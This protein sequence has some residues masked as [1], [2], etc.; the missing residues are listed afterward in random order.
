MAATTHPALSLALIFGAG[1]RGVAG[2]YLALRTADLTII[3]PIIVT[4]MFAIQVV[5]VVACDK[6][7]DGRYGCDS[8]RSPNGTSKMV[9]SSLSMLSSSSSSSSGSRGSRSL[10]SRSMSAAL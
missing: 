3:R 10:A 8:S 5:T 1:F 6:G 9:P 7:R 2:W 4:S